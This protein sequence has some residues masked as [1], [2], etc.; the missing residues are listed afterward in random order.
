METT[1]TIASEQGD[2]TI[3]QTCRHEAGFVVSSKYVAHKGGTFTAYS[4]KKSGK[5]AK[6]SWGEMAAKRFVWAKK[7]AD[8]Y[9][10]A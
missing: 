7:S 6:F 2:M 4:L 10:A 1:Y 9:F 8:Q 3:T 5:W